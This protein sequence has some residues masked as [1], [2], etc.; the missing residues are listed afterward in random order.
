M[1]LL[2]RQNHKM[3]TYTQIEYSARLGCTIMVELNLSITIKLVKCVKGSRVGVDGH[4]RTLSVKS[5]KKTLANRTSLQFCVC[6]FLFLG[7]GGGSK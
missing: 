6:I 7:G 2:L 1:N 5:R 4:D 3:G